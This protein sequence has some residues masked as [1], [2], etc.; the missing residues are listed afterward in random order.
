MT[1]YWLSHFLIDA[2]QLYFVVILAFIIGLAAGLSIG[3]SSL[4]V[5]GGVLV[6]IIFMIIYVP[7]EVLFSYCL[8]FLFKE[9]KTCQSVAQIFYILVS[10]CLLCWTRVVP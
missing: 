6:F 4:T 7:L 10:R 2:A 8:G 3:V 1:S 9:I 5:G